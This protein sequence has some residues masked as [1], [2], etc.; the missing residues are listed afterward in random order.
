MFFSV[1][2]FLFIVCNIYG[3]SSK[4]DLLWTEYDEMYGLD[5]LLYN[6]KKYF[7]EIY[8]IK[9]HPFLRSQ[10]ELS[11]DLYMNGKV[12]QH[13]KLRYNLSIQEFIMSFS[14]SKGQHYPIILTNS[15]ID[16]VRIEGLLFVKNRF[17]GISQ[18]FIQ[19][20]YQGKLSCY[21]GWYKDIFY[22]TSG[23]KIRSA[24]SEERKDYYLIMD[25]EVNKFHN[26]SNFLKYF[27]RKGRKGIKKYWSVNKLKLKNIKDEKLEQL[28]I[29]CESIL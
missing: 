18:P 11:A 28:I 23:G 17:H 24:F 9:G 7:S 19:N 5:M 22:K 13:C 1:C 2:A 20:I 26:K 10:D 4:V 12:F 29:F 6:G 15:F 8:P 16:S 14:T 27:S 3:Q 25:N 21:A